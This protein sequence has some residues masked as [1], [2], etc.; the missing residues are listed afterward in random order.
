M[1][2]AAVRLS[3]P[4]LIEHL[5]QAGDP[6]EVASLL[7]RFPSVAFQVH[8]DNV[9]GLLKAMA[10]TRGDAQAFVLKAV[11]ARGPGLMCA[12]DVTR[13]LFLAQQVGQQG[14]ALG[15]EAL[16]EAWQ[17]AGLRPAEQ[18]GLTGWV[19]R[20][21]LRAR[22]ASVWAA[23][24]ACPGQAQRPDRLPLAFQAARQATEFDWGWRF[25]PQASWQARVHAAWDVLSRGWPP[26]PV[27]FAIDDPGTAAGVT[28]T[29]VED[30]PWS[31]PEVTAALATVF[32]GPA[33]PFKTLV[34]N[35][36]GPDPDPHRRLRALEACLPLAAT[37]ER[38]KVAL[39]CGTRALERAHRRQRERLPALA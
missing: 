9:E 25:L 4:A 20:H 24:E 15:V 37:L 34:E 14:S 16:R 19:G 31:Q 32:N 7:H 35:D 6:V 18:E 22:H 11:L 28:H 36:Y 10:V 12:V 21:A 3:S 27:P 2:P 1:Q 13:H 39:A 26:R 33:S 29:L 30:L 5:G 38:R 17:I 8:P 23:V